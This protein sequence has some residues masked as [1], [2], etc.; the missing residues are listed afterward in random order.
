MYFGVGQVFAHVVGSEYFQYTAQD[1]DAVSFQVSRK[2]MKDSLKK[3]I[4]PF[5]L[6]S[7]QTGNQTHHFFSQIL[8]NTS[9][10][11]KVNIFTDVQPI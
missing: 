10:C 5:E 7:T 9:P 4:E 1:F 11:C 3:N 6:F 8:E 2:K